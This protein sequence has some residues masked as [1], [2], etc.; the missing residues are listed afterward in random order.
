METSQDTD[1][2]SDERRLIVNHV[3]SAASMELESSNQPIWIIDSA[4]TCHICK[5]CEAFVELKSTR[6]SIILLLKMAMH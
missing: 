6:K 4:A 3:P 5:D 2:K 1:S